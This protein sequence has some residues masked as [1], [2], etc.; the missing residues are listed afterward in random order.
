LGEFTKIGGRASRKSSS[1]EIYGKG[2]VP[3]SGR[4]EKRPQTSAKIQT[5][6]KRG[7]KQLAVTSS[8][9][10]GEGRRGTLIKRDACATPTSRRKT[11]FKLE[12]SGT[13]GIEETA[14]FRKKEG[15]WQGECHFLK[16]RHNIT[17]RLRPKTT[18]PR[19]M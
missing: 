13:G 6:G 10:F 7:Q 14:K 9:S 5:L 3:K 18:I 4:E 16:C 2:R 17:N 12:N 11:F 19:P 1:G 15:D 8:C